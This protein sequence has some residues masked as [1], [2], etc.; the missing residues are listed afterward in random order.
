M[1]ND[2]FSSSAQAAPAA[3]GRLS[4]HVYAAVKTRLLE[5]EIRAGARL[6]V[7]DLRGEFGVSK[8]PVMEALRLL[9]GDGLVEILPQIG[10]VVTAYPQ[11]EVH[12]FFRMFAGFE[13]AIAAVAATRS[14]PQAIRDL[15]AISAR[16][17]EV[18]QNPDD[19]VRARGYRELNRQFHEQIH[20]MAASRII[21]TTSRRMWDLSDFLINTHGAPHPLASHIDE[22]QRD[23][24]RIR[25]ALDAQDPVAAEA[26]MERHILETTSLFEEAPQRMGERAS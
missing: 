3:G 14:T 22:R 23:H 2:L 12:D 17:D 1:A 25:E 9:A 5:G 26:E 4:A 7:A 20:R 16:I 24:N 8:Q 11:Q 13:G 21:T 6:S 10:C 15:D 18:A 19:L